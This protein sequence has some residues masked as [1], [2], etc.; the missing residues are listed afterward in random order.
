M[1]ISGFDQIRFGIMCATTLNQAFLSSLVAFMLSEFQ[2]HLLLSLFISSKVVWYHISTLVIQYSLKDF[3]SSK[4]TQSG[5]VST[6]IQITLNLD[7]SLIF[8]ASSIE[9]DFF[10]SYHF[11]SLK[12]ANLSFEKSMLSINWLISS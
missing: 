4:D 10:C 2:C 1:S 3:I 8:L 9:L 5:R 6:A 7:D 11:F 12:V